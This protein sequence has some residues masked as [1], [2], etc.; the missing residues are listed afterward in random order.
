MLLDKGVACLA[1]IHFGGKNPH[2][3]E[4]YVRFSY[5]TAKDEIVEGMK[6]VKE[7]VEG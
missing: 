2:Q 3:T 6:R 1:D 7:F 4:E 5:A